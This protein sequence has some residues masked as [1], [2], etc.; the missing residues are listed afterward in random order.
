[1]AFQDYQTMFTQVQLILQMF[2]E[3]AKAGGSTE[4]SF[5]KLDDI[6]G[7]ATDD[8]HKGEIPVFFAQNFVM[9]TGGGAGGTGKASPSDYFLVIPLDMS[10]PPLQQ[11]GASGKTFNQATISFRRSEKGEQKEYEV[12][13]LKDIRVSLY[14]ETTTPVPTHPHVAVIA[15]QFS[16]IQWTH[17]STKAGRNYSQNKNT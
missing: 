5:L 14:Y 8:K 7:S 11:A 1:M 10:C 2:V 17:G 3:K 12:D 15:L 6:K 4:D 16:E 13:T 9:Q